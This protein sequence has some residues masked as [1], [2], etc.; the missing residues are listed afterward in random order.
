M[1]ADLKHEN[2][3]VRYWAAIHLGN[4]A[5]QVSNMTPLEERLNDPVPVVQTAAARALCKMNRPEK[6][7]PTLEQILQNKDE[8]NRLQAAQVLDEIGYQAQP[9]ISALQGVMED[10]NKYVVR[11]ANRALNQMLGT[12]NVVK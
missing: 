9:S 11:V 6:A 5:A 7:L 8:W 4:K 2:D 10:Q 1:E 12:N 3:A